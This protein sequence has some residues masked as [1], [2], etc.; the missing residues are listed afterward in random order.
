MDLFDDFIKVALLT[1]GPFGTAGLPTL[2]IS[3]PGAGKSIRVRKTAQRYG[4]SPYRAIELSKSTPEDIGGF[5]TPNEKR[6]HRL[7]VGPFADLVEAERGVLLIDELTWCPHA[8]QG[9]ALRVILEHVVGDHNM[10]RYVRVLAAAN[11]VNMAGSDLI[12]AL[13]NRMIIVNLEPDL[14][15]YSSYMLGIK[16]QEEN[17]TTEINEQ[18]IESEFNPL[19]TKAQAQVVGFLRRCPELLSKPLADDADD[20]AW[21]SGRS[22]DLAARVVAGCQLHNIRTEARSQLIAGTIGKGAAAQFLAFLNTVSILPDPEDVLAN[23]NGNYLYKQKPDLQI[24]LVASVTAAAVSQHKD[25]TNRMVRCSQYFLSVLEA[26]MT[27]HAIPGVKD[28]LEAKRDI[29]NEKGA[30]EPFAKFL[31]LLSDIP[32]IR[33]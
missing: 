3:P 20:M 15:E 14:D 25:R 12:A 30:R 11:P 24:A 13:T 31:P 8:M 28:L 23:P 22:W 1:P 18:Q 6:V 26:G 2:F 5:P 4:L 32:E 10:G 17:E 16:R 9:A 7:P 29:F 19:Y 27:E 21:P 33:G